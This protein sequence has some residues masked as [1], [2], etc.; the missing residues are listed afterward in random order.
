MGCYY[1]IIM[2]LQKSPKIL[3]SL[4]KNIEKILRNDS[5]DAIKSSF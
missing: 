4:C 1:D 3:Q 2:M 5:L